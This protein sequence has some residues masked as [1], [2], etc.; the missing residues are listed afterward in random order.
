[1]IL[2]KRRANFKRW[3]KFAGECTKSLSDEQRLMLEMAGSASPKSRRGLVGSLTRVGM[4]KKQVDEV[5]RIHELL[6]KRRKDY[7]VVDEFLE[8]YK[9]VAKK[10]RPGE[11][12]LS[13]REMLSKSDGASSL[14]IRELI[15]LGVASVRGNVGWLRNIIVRIIKML[16]NE[17]IFRAQSANFRDMNQVKDLSKSVIVLL[18]KMRGKLT[19]DAYKILVHQLDSI[20]GS[21]ESKKGVYSSGATWSLAQFRDKITSGRYEPEFIGFWIQ[22]LISRTAA[23]EV[24]TL[25]KKVMTKKYIEAMPIS[26]IWLLHYYYPLD[27]DLRNILSNKILKAYNSED[28]YLQYLAI[29]LLENGIIK[30]EMMAKDEEFKRALFQIKRDF[31]HRTL[32]SGI[33]IHFSLHNLMLL[34]DKDHRHLWWL[35]L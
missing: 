34:G 35:V 15:K 20:I 23:R 22:E 32:S 17:I 19:G 24:R 25:L 30:K 1:M 31:Y 27:G 10:D 29:S 26:N 5:T 6:G 16:P 8:Y 28:Y 2:D 3:Q 9:S 33:A 13:S 7:K 11:I 4:S 14:L 18:E 21:A 12:Y